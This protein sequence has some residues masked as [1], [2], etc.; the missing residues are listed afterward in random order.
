MRGL[1]VEMPILDN[2]VE[3]G[4]L[5]FAPLMFAARFLPLTVDGLRALTRPVPRGIVP[6]WAGIALDT[7]R[8][9]ARRRWPR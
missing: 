5:A 2:A 6:F 4:I 7:L 8:P 9:A 3:A 1:I